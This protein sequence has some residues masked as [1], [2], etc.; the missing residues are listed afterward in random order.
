M[1]WKK[2]ILPDSSLQHLIDKVIFRDIAAQDEENERVFY[3]RRA[4]S[5]VTL[6]NGQPEQN[7]PA[8]MKIE[9]ATSAGNPAKTKGKI[10]GKRQ[11]M[12]PSPQAD[13]IGKTEHIRLVPANSSTIKDEW[14]SSSASSVSSLGNGIDTS[15]Q[16]SE[17]PPALDKPCLQVPGNMSMA[18]LKKYLNLKLPDWS[19][20]D[21]FLEGKR[22][23]NE[24]TVGF[25]KRA[26]WTPL[27]EKAILTLHYL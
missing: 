4:A 24:W 21:I 11:S 8:K 14:P 22:L 12:Q 16:L 13:G 7:Q 2:H 5:N 26:M 25:V 9:T 10:Q 1:D 3:E 15:Q 23:G 6:E 18:Q 17:W 19:A 27:S 20:Q